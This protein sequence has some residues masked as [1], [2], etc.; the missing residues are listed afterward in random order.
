MGKRRTSKWSLKLFRKLI[1]FFFQFIGKL[2]PFAITAGVVGFIFIGVRQMLYADPYFR[3]NQVTVFPS[4]ILT[5]AEHHFLEHETRQRSLIAIDLKEL[6]RSLERNPNVKRAEVNRILPDQ[7]N[8]FLTTR[9]PFIQIQLKQGGPYYLIASDQLVLAVE[10][11][12]RSNLI[13]LEDFNPEKKTYSVGTL[14][15]NKYFQ[16]LFDI[17]G[18]LARDPLLNTET[19]LKLEMD[20]TGNVN[21]VLKDGVELRVGSRLM[22]SDD[23][24][25]VLSS[26]LRSDQRHDIL[27]VDMRYRDIIVK[28]KSQT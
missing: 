25:A 3:V 8:I 26:I 2:V 27:Y 11:E 1:P 20:Q 7:L 21:I 14:Y 18:S 23:S 6:S 19:V 10:A 4:G 5:E 16:E 12:P 22:L 17:F 15:R 28:K 9:L 24:R 13:L